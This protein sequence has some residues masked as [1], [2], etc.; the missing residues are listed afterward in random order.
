MVYVMRKNPAGNEYDIPQHIAELME[1]QLGCTTAGAAKH[2]LRWELNGLG[3]IFFHKISRAK[4]SIYILPSTPRKWKT[5]ERLQTVLEKWGYA[6]L[7]DEVSNRKGTDKHLEIHNVVW[8]QMEEIAPNLVDWVY[9]NE[10]GSHIIPLEE[11]SKSKNNAGFVKRKRVSKNLVRSAIDNLGKTG[12][13]SLNEILTQMELEAH[14]GNYELADR[15]KENV[16]EILE[17]I[18]EEK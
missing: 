13:V 17:E 5:R 18:L 15:W 14:T 7:I 12:N 1:D 4:C 2:G 11:Y 6:N 10:R 16:M 3:T 9:F 8:R